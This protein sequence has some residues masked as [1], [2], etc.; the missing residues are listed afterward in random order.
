MSLGKEQ[1]GVPSA[2]MV[3]TQ[4]DQGFGTKEGCG[5]ADQEPRG[6]PW[7][8][9]A[10]IRP[11]NVSGHK[12]PE[13]KGLQMP[14]AAVGHPRRGSSSKLHH[15]GAPISTPTS[16]TERNEFC[17]LR[18]TQSMISHYSSPDGRRETNKHLLKLAMC[19]ALF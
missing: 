15:V 6:L 10:F 2:A 16:R 13:D 18:A 4:H 14:L 11:L 19:Q 3:S 5:V 9:K 8:G 12:E 7:E 1:G 17:G